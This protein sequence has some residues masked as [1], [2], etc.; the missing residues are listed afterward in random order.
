MKTITIHTDYIQLDQALKKEG[1][2]STGGEIAPYLEMHRVT[3]NGAPVHEKRKK[4]REETC[5]LWTA[6]P[7][8][9][10]ASHE[11]RLFPSDPDP[12]SGGR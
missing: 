12:Q 2:I 11:C 7:T 1:I 8:A 5:S 4:L 3:L 10:S 9:S 6:T